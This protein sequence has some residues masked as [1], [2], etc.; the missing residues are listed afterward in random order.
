M[1]SWEKALAVDPSQVY[2]HLYLG[3]QLDSEQKFDAAIPQYMMFLERVTK[4]GARPDPNVVLPVLMKLAECNL[5]T[6]RPERAMKLYN[7]A[8]TVASQNNAPRIESVASLNQAILESKSG[9]ANDALS[10]YQRALK[11]DRSANDPAA[12][13]VDWQA[14][15][16]FLNERGY[17]KKFAYACML[18]AEALLGQVKTA[19]IPPPTQLRAKLESELGKDAMAI[20]KDTTPLLEQALQLQSK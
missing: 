4:A 20:R 19:P 3:E 8:R 15:G 11:L 9:Q 5:R 16:V 18:R 2:A 10:L 1:A 13:A 14:Y 7:L 6:N 12:E 17:P